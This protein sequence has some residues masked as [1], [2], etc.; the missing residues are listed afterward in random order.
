M[1]TTTALITAEAYLQMADNGQPTELVRGEVITMPP[2]TPR[3]GQICFRAGYLL[4]RY[5]DDHPSGCIVSSG[6]RCSRDP[7][8]QSRYGAR[9][10]C[11]LLQL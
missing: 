5:L 8:T 10:R 6:Q 3:H 7:G 1:S 2:P 4:Q 9:A 11:G